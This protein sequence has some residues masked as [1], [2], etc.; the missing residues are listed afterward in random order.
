MNGPQKFAYYFI[1]IAMTSVIAGLATAPFSLYHFQQFAGYGGIIANLVAIP[2]MAFWVMPAAIVSML[3]MP[4]GLEKLPLIVM[5]AGIESMMEAA[6]FAADLEGSVIKAPLFSFL[7]FLG[8]ACGLLFFILWQG[9]LRHIGIVVFIISCLFIFNTKQPLALV[10]S[11]NKLVALNHPNEHLKVS[12]LRREKFVRENWERALGL[13]KDSAKVFGSSKNDTCGDLGCRMI[14]ADQKIAYSLSPYTHK[15]D[16]AWADI[17]LAK[18]P[19]RQDCSAKVID[20][21]DTYYE[22]AHAV[23][24]HEG[25]LD[26]QSVKEALYLKRPWNYSGKD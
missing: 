11:T 13:E 14:V 2:L 1:G 21:F 7:S 3:S 25:R 6:R 9:A 22:G 10:S 4:L 24:L 26:I 8:I 18:D 17:V 20:F 12:T 19:V 5:G 15:S 23:Y 16:C